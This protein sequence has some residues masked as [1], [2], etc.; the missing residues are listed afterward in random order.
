MLAHAWRAT[1]DH[2]GRRREADGKSVDVV[3]GHFAVVAAGTEAAPRKSFP[4]E[5]TVKFGPAD[6]VLKPGWVLDSGDEFTSAR[7]YGWVGKG[8]EPTGI[9]W[10]NPST[11]VKEYAGR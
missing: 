7:G 3:T 6:V 10:T 4:D 11:G 9:T 1:F 8:G 5:V 2:P